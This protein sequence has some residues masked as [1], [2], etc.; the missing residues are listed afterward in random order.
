[1]I[2]DFAA[3]GGIRDGV[4]DAW[5]R[6]NGMR[7][8]AVGIGNQKPGNGLEVL[9]SGRANSLTFMERSLPADLITATGLRNIGVRAT[10]GGD[11]YS[12]SLGV[13]GD[14][15]NNNN[16]TL[17]ADEGWGVHGRASYAPIATADK[18]AHVGVSGY[19]RTIGADRGVNNV[20]NARQFRFRARPEINVDGNR[21]VDSGV[22]ANAEEARLLGVELAGVYGPVSVQG[23][24]VVVAVDQDGPAASHELVFDGGYVMAS[25]FL[26]GE[27]RV[28]DARNGIF[29]RFKPKR[30]FS[31]SEGGWGAWELA[32]RAS[33]IDLN[34][35]PDNLAGGGVR[36]GEQLDYTVGLNWYLNPY[37]RM[38]FNYVH[39]DADNLSAAGLQK[40]AT[41]DIYALRA[42]FEW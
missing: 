38:M 8:V 42:Q 36:G 35:H 10:T 32:L 31:L 30:N 15:I 22:L 29:G 16:V 24:Y 7:P 6:Y 9:M 17:D 13:F 14:D 3:A 21:L 41:V 1:M 33:F 11:H 2:A 18:V 23:E 5:L 20:A 4:R 28:Y 12:A 34:S 19:W 27:S 40:G 37:V 39:A 25:Y 26:T